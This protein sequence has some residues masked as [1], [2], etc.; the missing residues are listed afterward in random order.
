MQ[1][2]PIYISWNVHLSSEE[3]GEKVGRVLDAFSVDKGFVVDEVRVNP[4]GVPVSMSEVHPVGDYFEDIHAQADYSYTRQLHLVFQRIPSSKRFW[5]DVMMNVLASI[6]NSLD[7]AA[8][9]LEYKGVDPPPFYGPQLVAPDLS[10][11]EW[12]SS[13]GENSRRFWTIAACYLLNH[14]SFTFEDLSIDSGVPVESLRSMHRNS[15]KGIHAKRGSN[16]LV[17][18]WDEEHRRF[19]YTMNRHVRDEFLKLSTI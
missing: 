1:T 18:H 6:K 8:I 10:V 13:L 19:I 7:G 17:S 9:T 15:W 12:F 11:A 5:K 2:E 3:D 4:A 16:P 14:E